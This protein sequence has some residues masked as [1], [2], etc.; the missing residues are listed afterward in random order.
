[1]W[2]TVSLA[3]PIVALVADKGGNYGDEYRLKGS[4]LGGGGKDPGEHPLS[5]TCH[6]SL[7]SFSELPC[8]TVRKLVFFSS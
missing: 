1:M 5:L 3:F 7:V 2:V 6:P 4:E 8:L